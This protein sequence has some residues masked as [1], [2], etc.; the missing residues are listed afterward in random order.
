VRFRKGEQPAERTALISLAG[1][2]TRASCQA[3]SAS[4]TLMISVSLQTTIDLFA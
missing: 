4:D 1:S 2:A 3:H